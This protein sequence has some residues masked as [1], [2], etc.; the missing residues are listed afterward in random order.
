MGAQGKPTHRSRR[1]GEPAPNL[2]RGPLTINVTVPSFVPTPRLATDVYAG[3]PLT[4]DP[5]EYWPVRLCAPVAMLLI[6]CL[7]QLL[8]SRL[9]GRFLHGSSPIKSDGPLWEPRFCSE[10]TCPQ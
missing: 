7:G 10:P 2:Q 8:I 1:R 9:K 6:V 5:H 3:P 4:V